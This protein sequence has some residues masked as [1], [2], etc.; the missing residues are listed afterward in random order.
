MSAALGLSIGVANLVAA[1]AGGVPVSRRSVLTLFDRRPSEVGLGDQGP[2]SNEAGLVVRGFVERVGDRAPLVAADGKRYLGAGLTVEALDAMARIVGNGAPIAIAVPTYWSDDQTAALRDEFR[3]QSNLAPN[4][5]APMLVSDA[6]AAGAGLHAKPGFPTSGI[7]ALCDFGAGGASITLLKPGANFQQVGQPVRRTGFSGDNIDQLIANHLQARARNARTASLKDAVRTGLQGLSPR[8]CRRVKEQLSTVEVT[9]IGADFG[10]DIRLS[11]KDFEN[12]ILPL[13]DQ[14]ITSVEEALQRNAIPAGSLAAVAIVG[15]GASIPL[16]STRLSERLRVSVFTTPQPAFTAA[17]GAAI[18]AQQ[19]SSA[20]PRRTPSPAVVAP[21]TMA[22]TPPPRA[23]T[24]APTMAAAPPTMAA[25]PPRIVTPPPPRIVTPPPRSVTPPP[26]AST[27]PTVAGSRPETQT[28]PTPS[29]DGG[30]HAAGQAPPAALAWSEAT[31]TGGE[32][33]PYTGPE[34]TDERVEETPADPE[35]DHDEDPKP[36]TKPAKLPWYKRTVLILTVA[37]ACVAVVAAVGLALGLVGLKKTIPSTQTSTETT[38]QTTTVTTPSTTT[39]SEVPSP[40]TEPS[41]TPTYTPPATPT[42]VPP[43]PTNTS[44]TR[45]NQPPTTT[46]SQ[47]P[48]RSPQ[49][50]SPPV[51]TSHRGLFPPFGPPTPKH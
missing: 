35:D 49:T 8:D 48:T 3:G 1:R 47:K 25:P 9:P 15:G 20:G 5:A 34:H 6:K 44:P 19:Q 45:T 24:P 29:S 51:T 30:G 42:Y 50:S 14:F 46:P 33:V 41:E 22:A 43:P 32:P 26:V 38:S 31:G 7:V 37:S 4:G 12:L 11:R 2:D 10:M 17:I 39:T 40:V 13:L 36:P 28:T 21:P 16:L 18:L 27:P 23:V